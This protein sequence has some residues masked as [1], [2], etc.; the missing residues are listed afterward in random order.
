MIS[1][2]PAPVDVIHT[3][4]DRDPADNAKNRCGVA[5]AIQMFHISA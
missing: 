5:A 1:V 3:G 2:M 4:E